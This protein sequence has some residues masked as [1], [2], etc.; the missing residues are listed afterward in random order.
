MCAPYCPEVG[1]PRAPRYPATAFTSPTEGAG[2][3]LFRDGITLG[4]SSQVS[5]RNPAAHLVVAAELL[6]NLIGELTSARPELDSVFLGVLVRF[7]A[8]H[9][10]AIIVPRL[11]R[12]DQ[13]I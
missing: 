5:S 13:L 2:E 8:K 10:I 4:G 11:Q 7:S 6:L 3:P 12:I 1:R 9:K